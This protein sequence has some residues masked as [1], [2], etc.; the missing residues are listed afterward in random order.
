MSRQLE[1]PDAIALTAEQKAIAGPQLG[2]CLKQRIA[3]HHSGMSYSQRAALVEP[4][5]KASQLKVI[6]ATTGLAAGINFAMRSVLISD[7]EYRVAEAHRYLRSDE[8]LQMFGR[9]GRRGLDARGYALQT[10]GT[11]RLSEARPTALKRE[12]KVDWP[13][14]ITV[15]QVAAESGNSPL[16]ATRNLTRR[17]FTKRPIVLGLDNFLKRRESA[18]TSATTEK[19]AEQVLSGGTVRE[20]LNSEGIWERKRAASPAPLKD[21]LMRRGE[22][23]FPA[24]ASPKIPSSLRLGT[25][26]KSGRGKDKR[27]GLKVI[28][29][30]FPT[31]ADQDK[32]LLAKWLR[33]VLREEAREAGERPNVPKY[34]KLEKIEAK[35]VPQIARYTN[36]GHAEKLA[37]H[38]DHLTAYLHYGDAQMHAYKDLQGKALLNPKE[39]TRHIPGG[40]EGRGEAV[41]TA[42]RAHSVAEQWFQLGL[43][44]R[45]ARPTRRGIVFSFFNHAEGLA[46]AAGLEDENYAIEDLLYDL[47]NIRAGHRFNALALGGRPLTHLCQKN[48]G[49]INIPGYLRRGL[50]EDYGEGASEVLYNI[51]TGSSHAAAYLDEELSRGDIER[52]QLE[53][54]SL[55]MH[56]AHAPD[57]DWSRWMALKAAC[58][59]SIESEQ[60]ALPFE[61]LPSLT[62]QQSSTRTWQKLA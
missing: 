55:R 33:R 5:A 48:Y 2:A 54:R 6:V 40:R 20:F 59:R 4:L 15:L 28:L 23:W 7:N 25:L 52:A 12:D 62:P 49:A 47:A 19:P 22:E 44:D 42:G 1:E 53:W 14:L 58:R 39:R 32:L 45:Q 41:R 60:R 43:I 27:Y 38:G 46:V 30:K 37:V 57:Y 34:W 11:P 24:L 26:W 36:G 50:P 16:Q 8:L 31:E 9:A 10:T 18:P 51:D 21:C 35:I 56:I 13:S 29:A 3:F 17:L 61:D